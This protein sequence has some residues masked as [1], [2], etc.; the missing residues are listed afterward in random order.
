MLRGLVVTENITVDVAV[1]GAGAGGSLTAL[2]LNQIGLRVV[3]L[4]RGSHPR[5]AIGE[6]STPVAGMVL[7]DLAKRYELPFLLPLSRYGMW[8]QSCDELVCGPKRGFSYFKQRAGLPFLPQADHSNELL[9]AASQSHASADTHWLRCDVDTFLVDQVRAAGIPYFDQTGVTILKTSPAWHLK[10]SRQ[11]AVLNIR[12]SFVIDATGEAALIPRALGIKDGIHQMRTNSRALFGHFAGVT[13]WQETFGSN[14]THTS[15]H[16]FR[17]DEAAL[18]HLLEEG[19]MWQL[20]F[21]NGVTSAGIAL[22]GLKHALNRAISAEQDWDAVLS[23]YPSLVE[24][25]ASAQVISP[26][27]GMCQTGRLQRRWLQAA[28]ENWALLPN[29]AGFVDPLYSAG[30]AHTMCGV[31]QIVHRIEHHW[32]RK[33]LRQQMQQYGAIVQSELDLI[34]ELVHSSYRALKDFDLFVPFSMLYFAAA[35]TYEQRRL[36]KGFSPERAFLCAKDE[37]FRSITRQLRRELAAALTQPQ[38]RTTINRFFQTVAQ[39]I[40]P[41]NT[42]GLC[43]TRAGNMYRYTAVDI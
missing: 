43:N 5:F 20:R 19:W 32:G 29:T 27:S 3:L 21:D 12:A 39:L 22:N 2:L 13:P 30:L 41:F 26:D 23:R 10:A 40:S 31:E 28:G 38:S 25:F 14:Q 35:T 15:A 8:K 36:Q 16:P 17:C 42:A 9:V 34:D 1:A 37:G 7:R 6:S 18:H 11:Q 33:T 4:E 24:Q